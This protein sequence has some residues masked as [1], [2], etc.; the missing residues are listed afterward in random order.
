MIV[1]YN[2]LEDNTEELQ[3]G[4]FTVLEQLPGK[5]IVQDQTEVLRNRTYWKS[6]NRAFY[7]EIFELSG[8]QEKV[9][10]YGDWFTHDKTPRSKIIDRDHGKIKDLESFMSFM[11]Y[12]DFENDPLAKVSGC[13]PEN[14]PAGSIANRLDL[15]DPN[16]NCSFAEYDHM[17]GHWGYGALDAKVASKLSFPL[18]NFD[19]VAG[20][21]HDQH[22]PFAWSTTNI[23][24][25][26]PKFMP[27][28]KFDFEPI[29]TEWAL[30]DGQVPNLR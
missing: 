20:P 26:K 19:A 24:D 5:F 22:E 18:L 30:N 15:S 8:A 21:T 16:L 28:D 1:D 14:I 29:N 10:K 9:D 3:D 23:P 12:N 17:V 7:P 4:V 2:K 27:I 25:K 11:R 13:D 6:Y